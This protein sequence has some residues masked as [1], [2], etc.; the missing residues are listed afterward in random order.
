MAGDS[1]RVVE[2]RAL[3][4]LLLP[5]GLVVRSIPVRTL[6]KQ[7]GV[8]RDFGQLECVAQA[9]GTPLPCFGCRSCDV[10]WSTC[11]HPCCV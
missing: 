7:L 6:V 2:E 10:C 8:S 9:A 1:E 4:E 5:L 3:E 11:L